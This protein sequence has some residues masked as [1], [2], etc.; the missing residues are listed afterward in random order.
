MTTDSVYTADELLGSLLRIEEKLDRLL[1]ERPIVPG[2]AATL[3]RRM[4]LRER[5][6]REQAES[7]QD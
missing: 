2:Q 4:E 5:E 6:R 1:A 3:Q 7:V